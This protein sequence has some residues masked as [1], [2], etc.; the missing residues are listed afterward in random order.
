MSHYNM[1]V[2]DRCG[3][4]KKFTTIEHPDFYTLELG[5]LQG[6]G[7]IKTDRYLY[8]CPECA[9]RLKEWLKGIQEES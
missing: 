1:Y 3:A 4:I 7:I 2:C 8:L 6:P 9:K 5:S